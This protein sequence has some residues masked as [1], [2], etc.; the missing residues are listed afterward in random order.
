[1]FARLRRI[2]FPRWRSTIQ[3]GVALAICIVLV[4]AL[5]PGFTLPRLTHY[6]SQGLFAALRGV[7]GTIFIA[8]SAWFA[9]CWSA[10]SLAVLGSAVAFLPL[11]A[12]EDARARHLNRDDD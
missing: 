4:V 11:F 9:L 1:M 8:Y 5:L 10:T 6:P 3:L 2:P 7:G 12:Y